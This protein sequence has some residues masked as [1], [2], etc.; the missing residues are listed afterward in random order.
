MGRRFLNERQPEGRHLFLH[1]KRLW[2]DVDVS[3]LF[4]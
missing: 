2:T 1:A 3:T 4:N